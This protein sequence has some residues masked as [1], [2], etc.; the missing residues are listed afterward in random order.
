M[1][2]L[3]SDDPWNQTAADNAEWLQRFKR[4]AGIL[5][6]ESG[7]GLLHHNVQW[8]ITDG[9]TGFAPP[10]VCLSPQVTLEPLKENPVVYCR[11]NS[12][13]FAPTAATANRFL[14]SL[15]QRYALPAKVFCS[16]ELENGLTEYVKREAG[17]TGV[18]PSDDQ[19]RERAK[20]IMGMQTTAADDSILLKKFKDSIEAAVMS[21]QLSDMQGLTGARLS[22]VS[23]GPLH[24]LVEDAT[25]G[26]MDPLPPGVDLDLSDEQV[27]DILN[28]IDPTFIMEL[29]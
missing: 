7:P 23:N 27:T 6:A 15:N 25:L 29:S 10:Y 12:K 3:C 26:T 9:G 28:D 1:L 13:P 8:N 2:T 20:L 5:Q 18:M 14:Q 24:S 19:L 11:E 17:K 22:S 16:R 21:T 4:D